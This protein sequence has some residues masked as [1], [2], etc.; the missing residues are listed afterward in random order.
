MHRGAAAPLVDV[1]IDLRRAGT[2]TGMFAVAAGA[3]VALAPT[4]GAAT[5]DEFY[6]LRVCESGNSYAT[7]TGNGYYGAYQ[8]SLQTWQG[9]GNIGLPSDASPDVQDEQAAILQAARGWQPWPACSRKLGLTS[10]GVIAASTGSVVVVSGPAV[11]TTPPPFAGTTFTTA[12]VGQY[13]AD[14]AT[15][16][17][18]MRARGWSITVDGYFGP[19]SAGVARNFAAEK[20]IDSGLPGQVDVAMWSA[21]WTLPV[22]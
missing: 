17:S 12:I 1:N 20:G 15:W 4:A 10:G 22:T 16:Q 3:V 2:A 8:F 7:N 21:A 5:P 14:V 6:Q 11:P 19:Q 9:M 18:R 13:N